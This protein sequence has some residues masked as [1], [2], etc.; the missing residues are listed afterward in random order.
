MFR[1]PSAPPT[2][3]CEPPVPFAFSQAR[4]VSATSLPDAAETSRLFSKKGSTPAPS[5][6]A[7]S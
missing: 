5:H 3:H 6:S 4:S 2:S 1:I 7:D